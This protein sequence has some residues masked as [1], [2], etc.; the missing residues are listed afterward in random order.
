[1]IIIPLKQNKKRR[2]NEK[3]RFEEKCLPIKHV[4]SNRVSVI[5]IV[6][7]SDVERERMREKRKSEKVRN[8]QETERQ[9]ELKL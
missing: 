8:G 3:K 2:E 9:R 4:G 5:I 7:K 1:M 6:T